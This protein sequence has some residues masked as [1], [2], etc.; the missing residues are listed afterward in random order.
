MFKIGTYV[1]YRSEGVCVISD[2]RTEA[3]NALGKSEQ[4]YIL[5]PIK[6]ISSIL[7]VPV[8]NETL[9]SKMRPLLSAEE[10][11]DLADELRDER[12]DLWSTDSRARNAML[13]EILASG[14]RRQIIVLINTITDM[15]KNPSTTEKRLTAG[16]QNILKRAKKMLVAEFSVTTDINSEDD[17]MRVLCG[18]SRCAPNEIPSR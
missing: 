8:N 5:A 18:E 14:D 1:S 9:T 7:Y 13:R 17:L 12:S 6:D 4:F 2:I 16:D 10:L 15:M 3:F 11:C